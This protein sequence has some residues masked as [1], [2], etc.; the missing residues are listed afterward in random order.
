M[1]KDQIV[2]DIYESYGTDS[3]VLF[4]IKEKSS[5]EAIVEFTIRR[6]ESSAGEKEIE[7]LKGLIESLHTDAFGIAPYNLYT[8][9][10]TNK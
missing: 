2:T 6:C 9:S 4:G 3:G 7:R 8:E 10:L 5:V 1:D